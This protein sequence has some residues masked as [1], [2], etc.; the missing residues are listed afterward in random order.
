M[1]FSNL[2]FLWTAF[3]PVIVLLYYFFRKKYKDQPVSSTLFW[4]EVMQ[5]TKVS[6]YLKHLQKNALL[7]LQLLALLFF[8]LALMNPFVKTSEIAGEQ[9]IWI[10]DTSASMLAKDGNHST[11]DLHKEEMESLASS[12]NGRPLTIITTGEEPETVVRQETNPSVI[13]SAIEKLEVTYE[14]EKLP[15]AIGLATAFTGDSATSIYLF[16]DSVERGELPIESENITWI[17]KGASEGIEN[18]AITRLAAT[19]L[20][21]TA[22]AL[23]QLKN[24]T[25]V[26]KV[27][28]LALLDEANQTIVEEEVSLA[29]GEEWSKTFDALPITKR[30]TAAIQVDDDYEVDNT[31]TTL[32]GTRTS[33][34]VIDQQMHQL[35][36]KGF[37][38][39][40]T[41]VKIV[42]SN[43]LEVVDDTIVV[44]NQTKLL[45][46]AKSPIVLIGRDDEAAKEVNGLVDVSQDSLFAFS[47]LEDVYVSAIYPAFEDYTTIATI[48]G[49][50]FIQRSKRGD[51]VIL[52]DIQQTDWPLHPSFPLFL[53][54]IQNELTEGT[55]NLGTFSPNESRAVSLASGEWSIYSSDDEYVSSIEG[56]TEFR[57]PIIP[58]IYTIRSDEEEKQL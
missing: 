28:K 40:N 22:L 3:I 34:M 57:A 47:A 1:G 26:S 41:D 5:E 32:I 46:A 51:L 25:E 16:S 48:G 52:A 23:V 43:E 42:P 8:V 55:Q 35:V 56:G 24:E 13:Q 15:K 39:L 31:T 2:L 19:A 27:A 30:L 4:D 17:V 29:A 14:E 11:F 6:P 50:P 54:G 58:G 37:Q 18:V 53:W 36:Q 21:D 44:T 45:E 49:E 33:Q 12:L 20:N 10:V 7:Y 38:A 9:S